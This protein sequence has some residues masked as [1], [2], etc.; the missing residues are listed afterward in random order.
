MNTIM[1]CPVCG[2]NEYD[3]SDV[4]EF[5]KRR[6]WGTCP[7]CGWYDIDYPQHPHISK[8]GFHNLYD[9]NGFRFNVDR[10]PMT[11]EEFI[12]IRTRT[13]GSLGDFAGYVGYAFIINRRPASRD[14]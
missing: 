10:D 2:G 8:S 6:I 5:G 1:D 9:I 3:V 11:I 12:A 13:G 4:K 14:P 7:D